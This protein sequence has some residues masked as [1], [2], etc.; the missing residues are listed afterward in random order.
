M[1]K[2]LRVVTENANDQKAVLNSKASRTSSVSILIDF[3]FYKIIFTRETVLR[4]RHGKVEF[5]ETRRIQRAESD[6]R[7]MCLVKIDREEIENY[8]RLSGKVTEAINTYCNYRYIK[9]H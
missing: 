1:V 6:A 8:R 5:E 9:Y 3:T 7:A 2:K 4:L